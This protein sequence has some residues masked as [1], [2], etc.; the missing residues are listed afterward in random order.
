[1]HPDYCIVTKESPAHAAVRDQIGDAV[2]CAIG[3]GLN[4]EWIKDAAEQHYVAVFEESLEAAKR[5]VSSGEE[6]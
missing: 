3:H 2:A 5:E 1:M 4:W 6:R